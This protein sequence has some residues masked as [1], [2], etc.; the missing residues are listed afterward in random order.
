MTDFER[1]LDNCLRDLEQ[2]ASSVDDCLA[3]HPEHAAQ[4][5]P[6]LLA[7]AY[8]ARGRS[9]QPSAAFK[10]RT[11]AKLTLNMQ[12]HP[13]RRSHFGLAFRRF[14]TGLAVIVVTL[15]ATGTAYAQGALPGD[16]LYEWKLAS[17]R[18]WRAVSLNPVAVDIAIANRR[19]IELNAVADDPVLRAQALEGYLE[20]VTRLET[21]IDAE[22]L[23]RI[24]PVIDPLEDSEPPTPMPT[25]PSAPE[26]TP[27]PEPATL[28]EPT[29]TI[30]PENIPT[31]P[32]PLP[33]LLR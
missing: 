14:A 20:V 29:Q 33:P 5:K 19:I 10:A 25:D 1:I 30:L 15:L 17:E 23:E 24:L 3:R 22:T 4:L 21:E 8:L 18:T 31:I 11:R 9:L 6:V 12:A 27:M 28:P 2:G 16:P 26:A 7:A 13:R 32:F